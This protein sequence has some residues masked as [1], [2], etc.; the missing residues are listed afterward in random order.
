MS[1]AIKK[2][3]PPDVPNT[4]AFQVLLE[5]APCESPNVK[6]HPNEDLAA[7]QYTGGTTGTAKG[8]MLTHTNLVSNALAFAAWIKGNPSPRNIPNRPSPFPHLWHDNQ[9]DC[10]HQFGRKNGSDAKV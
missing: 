3:R 8:A 6:L 10:T 5:K 2:P 9:H 1:I 4:L 7:L